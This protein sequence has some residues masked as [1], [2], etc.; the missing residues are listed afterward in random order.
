MNPVGKALWLIE[1]HLSSEL[2]LEQ[3]ATRCELSRFSLTRAFGATTGYSVMRYLRGRRLSE[4]A[5]ALAAGAPDIL[6]VALEAGYG[7]HEAFTRA[8]R[9]QFGLTPESLRAQRHLD[10][11]ALVEPFRMDRVQLIDLQ[12]PR[13]ETSEPLLIV[14]L[15]ERYTFETNEGIP[16][17]WQ[18]FV[19]YIGNIP[20]QVGWR[21]YGVC[22]NSDG[23][24][25]FDYIAGVEVSSFDGIPEQFRRVKIP[26]RSYAVFTHQGHISTIRDSFHSILNQWLPQ[27]GYRLAD[28]PEFERYSEDFNPVAETGFV[29]IWLPVEA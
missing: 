23:G 27:S 12:P 6:S 22:C 13:F 10:D 16:T 8:F 17:L 21:T 25:A 24:G 20:G 3:I 28:A 9:E 7:S 1:N 4:A 15:G 5:R 14:G 29:E 19:P 11:I 2:S 26:P 18:R